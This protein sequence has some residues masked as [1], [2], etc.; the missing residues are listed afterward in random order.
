MDETVISIGPG[1]E[2]RVTPNGAWFQRDDF[3]PIAFIA[4][5]QLEQAARTVDA[6][7]TTRADSK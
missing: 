4:H 1:F 3:H 5:S 2:L 6:L 7:R